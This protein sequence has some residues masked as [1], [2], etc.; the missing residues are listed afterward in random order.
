M[1]R[2]GGGYGG[3]IVVDPDSLRKA[4]GRIRTTVG[5]L[6]AV[7]SALGS[8][9]YPAM[10]AGVDAVVRDA[11]AGAQASV[12]GQVAPLEGMVTELTRR[13]FWA[14]YA[15]QLMAGFDL[16]GQAK[17]EFVNWLKDGTLL[18]FA[19]AGEA[20]AAGRELAV[21]YAGFRKD[22]QQLVDLAQCLRGAEA[23]SSPDALRSFSAGFV[24]RFGATNM[25]LVPRVIQ[26][27][28]WSQQIAFGFD[29]TDRHVLY[30]VARQWQGKELQQDPVRDLL[31]PF[32][33]AL[34]NATMSGQLARTTED[35]IASSD[36]TWA[37]AALLSQGGVFGTHFLLQCFRTGVVQKIAE[38][39]RYD[40]LAIGGEEPP[41]D[42]PYTLGRMWSQGGESL[43]YDTKQIVLE[44]LARNPEAA[45]QALQQPLNVQVWDRL[46][47]EQTITDPVAL[48]Y[49][50]GH[51]DDDGAAFGHAYVAATD[52]LNRD[53]GDLAAVHSGSELTRDA[54]L[55]MLDHDHDGMSAFKDGLATDLAHHHLADLFDS[56]V[57]L[58]PGD[59]NEVVVH[60]DVDLRLSAAA[61]TETLKHLGDQPSALGTVLHA[62]AV[63]QGALI[64]DGAAHGPGTST[65]WAYRAAAF[66]AHVLNAADL[67]RL[68]SFDAADG[69]HELIAGF[70]KSVVN[71]TIAIENPLASAVVHTGVDSAIDH[72]FPGPSPGVLMSDNTEAKALL[73]N[74]LH[75]AIVGGYYEAGYLGDDDARP[76]STIVPHGK[77]ISYG[78]AR[79]DARWDY[80][81]WMNG[82]SHVEQVSRQAM[83]EVSRAFQE[84]GIDLV[85]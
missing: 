43:P 37:T 46:G 55:Q 47:Q 28:E 49:Q 3:Q 71:D 25:E 24:A 9:W 85:R 18:E 83:S 74:S 27:M 16:S 38:R 62:G 70:F 59:P 21:I 61:L 54:L 7:R 10:P 78:D 53:P 76:P 77:L 36:D 8:V 19:D 23:Y 1:R 81:G 80:E 73:T 72:A 20:A 63:Y 67:R 29:V 79:G 75:A 65:E 58:D 14:Q 17:Q 22:P 44:A 57:A 4:A 52:H 12:L 56:A 41:H 34:A 66:D 48:I 35:E 31:A 82:N 68:D 69:R 6:T 30:D 39:S 11:V 2:D 33:I 50:Y 84:R 5:E 42:A 15:G 26:A 51:F 45:A 13:A 32:S 64:H 60:H 40:G